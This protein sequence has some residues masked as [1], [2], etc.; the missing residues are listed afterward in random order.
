MVR[1][2]V[3]TV[4]DWPLW[5][6][7]RLAALT[8]APHA[9]KSRLSDWHHGGEE[10][11]RARFASP[12]SCNIVALLDGRTVGM[13]TGLPW[14]GGGCELRSVWVSPGARGSG[15]GDGLIE[16]VGTWARRSGAVTLKLAVL[17]HNGAA[18]ALYQRNG[19]TIT[20]E[21]GE[22]L[23]DGVTRERVMRKELR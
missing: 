16:A 9:F 23:P 5:R 15:V 12:A 2:R 18:F 3:L 22:L 6:D 10:L 4:A 8:E 14:D 17:P 1:L 11:W 20:P 13:A 19:F 21:P 7:A